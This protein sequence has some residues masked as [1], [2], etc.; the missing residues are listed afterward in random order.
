MWQ[1]HDDWRRG[2]RGKGK[3]DVSLGAFRR[4]IIWP[5]PPGTPAALPP[6]GSNPVLAWLDAAGLPW[7]ATRAGLAAPVWRPCRQPVQVYPSAG[8]LN[9][10]QVH[11]SL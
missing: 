2:I 9:W 7:R 4:S 11:N 1:G 8:P 6:P 3:R 10:P 5:R